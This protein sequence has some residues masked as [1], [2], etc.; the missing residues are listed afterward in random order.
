MYTKIESQTPL[1]VVTLDEA[2]RQLNILDDSEHDLHIQMLIAGASDLAEGYTNRM[3]SE[4]VVNLVITGKQEFFLPYGEAT[5][6]AVPIVA[7]VA[8]DPISFSFDPI[9][10]IFTIDDGQIKSTDK[11]T[12]TYSAGYK[13]APNAAKLGVLML[14]STLFMNR[15]DS[16]VGLSV[17]DIPLGSRQILDRIKLPSI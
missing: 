5:E 16:I 9:S 11:V 14:I 12:L 13:V 4:G 7:T 17:S 15:E 6:D 8:S 1:A 3:L 2:K 10:Q